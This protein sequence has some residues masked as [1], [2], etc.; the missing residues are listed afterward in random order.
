ARVLQ[1]ESAE[2]DSEAAQEPLRP[3]CLAGS[4]RLPGRATPCPGRPAGHPRKGQSP[5]GMGCLQGETRRP[6]LP[7]HGQSSQ[8]PSP[9]RVIVRI[10][11]VS[12]VDV[13]GAPR[14]T[15][16]LARVLAARGHDIG[17][18]LGMGGST[19]RSYTALTKVV[20]KVR[21]ATGV[22]WPRTLLRP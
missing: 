18:V 8:E 17:V 3:G 22:V 15:L 4:F 19:G 9:G 12:G 1:D 6:A 14:S 13:G 10:L 5:G 11:F 21:E 7:P 16:E 20:I 2:L